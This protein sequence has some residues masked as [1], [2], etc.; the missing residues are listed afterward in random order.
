M[1]KK[2]LNESTAYI[3]G[4]FDLLHYGHIELFRKCK[5]IFK[6]VVVSINR[7][8]F[9]RRYKGVSPI[10]NLQHRLDMV[11]SI[12]YVDKVIVNVG[13]EDSRKAILEVK[14]D[15]IIHGDD[16]ELSSLMK[17]M[18]IDA[19]FLHSNNLEFYFL[20]YT[21][22]VSSTII[23]NVVGNKNKEIPICLFIA[24][25]SE[26]IS[27][28]MEYNFPV[29]CYTKTPPLYIDDK[30]T[31]KEVP[32]DDYGREAISYLQFIID[33]YD[34]LPLYTFFLQGRINDHCNSLFSY[35]DLLSPFTW[36]TNE[37]MSTD[38]EGSPYNCCGL[39]NDLTNLTGME[40]PKKFRFGRGGMFFVSK[41]AILSHPKSYYENIISYYQKRVVHYPWAQYMERL[42][43]LI[44]TGKSGE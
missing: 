18:N 28:V 37:M 26:D 44:L 6:E 4:T 36:V 15:Y 19:D 1:T 31:Y 32:I 38:A 13:D 21:K 17:Q 22:G 34:N 33:Y 2:P 29:I 12:R 39:G 41:Q 9:V 14:P 10:F 25:H 43:E 30:I 7:D 8:E 27:W 24:R 20:P 42:W 40:C 35:L 5:E 11:N 23:R 3:G 16:W